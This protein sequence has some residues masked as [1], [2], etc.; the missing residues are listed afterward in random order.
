MAVLDSATC[1]FD[2]AETRDGKHRLIEVKP[3]DC[4]SPRSRGRL[5]LELNPEFEMG[6]ARTL[7][8]ML[9]DWITQVRFEPVD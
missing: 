9:N 3:S 2:V 6:D 5:T 8:K 1:D 4:A 7:A